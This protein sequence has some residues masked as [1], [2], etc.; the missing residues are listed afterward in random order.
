MLAFEP[1]V[2]RFFKEEESR[3][4]ARVALVGLTV[5]REI[6]GDQNPVGETIKLNKV[7]FQVIGVLPAE[8]AT[9]YMDQD[10]AVVIQVLAA[11]HRVPGKDYVD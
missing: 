7:C 10:V 4:R 9:G 1:Q 8:G 5:V 11:M 3:R 2:V 6:F